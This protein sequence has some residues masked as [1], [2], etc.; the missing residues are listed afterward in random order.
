MAPD[1]KDG[2]S[3]I[4]ATSKFSVRVIYVKFASNERAV[5]CLCGC[6]KFACK[7]VRKVPCHHH[8]RDWKTSRAMQSV[9][10][11]DPRGRSCKQYRIR[12][13]MNNTPPP[14]P[15]ICARILA[16]QVSLSMK[17]CRTACRVVCLLQAMKPRKT[18]ANC[19]RF[20]TFLHLA[21]SSGACHP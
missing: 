5:S 13:R 3:T 4:L 9:T 17:S 19:D 12:E 21:K 11:A 14:P 15:P 10:Q 6:A 8:Q 7:R 1:A 18:N 20:K 16:Y 2:E